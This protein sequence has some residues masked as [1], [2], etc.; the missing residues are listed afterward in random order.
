M[1]KTGQ[2]IMKIIRNTQLSLF[3]QNIRKT[4]N[5]GQVRGRVYT[6]GKTNARVL[7]SLASPCRLTLDT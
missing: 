3:T 5:A 1:D 4:E 2:Q 6:L 7:I